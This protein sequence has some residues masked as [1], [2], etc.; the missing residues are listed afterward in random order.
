MKQQKARPTFCK[1]LQKASKPTP[2]QVY[3][4]ATILCLAALLFAVLVS[5]GDLVNQYFFY[6]TLDTGMDFFHSIEYV[7][8]R[9]GSSVHCI[10]RLQICSFTDCISWCQ[11]P[12]LKNGSNRF[13][14]LSA[15]AAASRICGCIRE[16]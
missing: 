12:F 6:D 10:R 2:M 4:A 3:C 9:M 13:W 16:R 5:H 11:N 15:S 14:I 1:N 8:G 7:K